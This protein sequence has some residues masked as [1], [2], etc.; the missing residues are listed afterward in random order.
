MKQFTVK[1][2]YTTQTGEIWISGPKGSFRIMRV[3]DHYS[4]C[5]YHPDLPGHAKFEEIHDLA[6]SEVPVPVK[7]KAL[8]A[9]IAF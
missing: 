9:S 3:N 5:T 8:S 1:H 7:G 4:A 2:I 6:V